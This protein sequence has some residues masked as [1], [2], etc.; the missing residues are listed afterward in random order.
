MAF[1]I[2]GSTLINRYAI[3]FTGICACARTETRSCAK[4][5]DVCT[6]LGVL[7]PQY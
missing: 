1:L 3:I 4:C 2:G 6:V 7:T 5:S